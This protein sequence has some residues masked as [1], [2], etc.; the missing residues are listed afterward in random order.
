[1]AEKEEDMTNEEA[2][3]FTDDA[4]TALEQANENV[5]KVL[6]GELVTAPDGKRISHELAYSLYEAAVRTKSTLDPEGRTMFRTMAEMAKP[7]LEPVSINWERL[8]QLAYQELRVATQQGKNANKATVGVRVGESLFT[9]KNKLRLVNE[10]RK[11]PL[12]TVLK[13]HPE[14]DLMH[15]PYAFAEFSAR[16]IFHYAVEKMPDT[17]S[18][19]EEAKATTV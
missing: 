12:G 15:K 13:Y 18:W 17:P 1:M 2:T 5:A 3:L 10:D 6:K 4:P 7:P 8:A 9:K 14:I 16:E 19:L 11:S